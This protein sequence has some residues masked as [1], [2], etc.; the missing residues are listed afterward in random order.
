[1][2][3]IRCSHCNRLLA[4]ASEVKALEIKCPRCKTITSLRATRLPSECPAPTV[5]ERPTRSLPHDPR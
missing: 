4:R 2:E 5:P 3:S 1:M